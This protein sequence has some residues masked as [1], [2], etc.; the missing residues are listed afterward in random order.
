MNKYSSVLQAMAAGTWDYARPLSKSSSAL[1][2]IASGQWRPRPVS[3]FGINGL[4]PRVA[5]LPM[6]QIRHQ[7][8]MP[9]GQEGDNLKP[10]AGGY[11]M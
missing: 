1:Q 2:A 11:S 10:N 6:N 8:T 7:L 5:A 4:D 3:G 9:A